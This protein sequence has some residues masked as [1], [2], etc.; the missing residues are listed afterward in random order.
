MAAIA[1]LAASG[2]PPNVD[3]CSP[4][5]IWFITSLLPKTADTGMNPPLKDLPK[6]TK[7][8]LTP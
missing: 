4:G 5:L 6:Q 7:S 1:I 8:G 3:P 2:F